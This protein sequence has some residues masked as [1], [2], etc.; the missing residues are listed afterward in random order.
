MIYSSK[1]GLW[2]LHVNGWDDE[3]MVSLPVDRT[4]VFLNGFLHS[5]T[6]CDI[7]A[8]DMEGKK[9]RKIP[10][11][12]PD[13]DIGIIHQTQGRLC[14]FNVDPNDILELSIWFLEDY[15]TDNWILK[16]TV[17]S[18]NLFGRKKYQLDFDYQV[19]AVHP[20]CNLIFFVYGWHNTLM[21]Y[22]MDRKEVRVIRKL[23]HESCLPYLP[24]VPMFSESLPDGWC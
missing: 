22:E 12:D 18:I 4:R 14:A 7:V 24:Y 23:G 10:M 15:D 2:S 5:V 13:G 19:I 9:W 1:T 3:V 16:H 17:S 20:E 11:P 6:T 8:V 21:A